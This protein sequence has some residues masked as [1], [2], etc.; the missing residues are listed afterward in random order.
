[1][2]QNIGLQY[3]SHEQTVCALVIVIAQLVSLICLA[4]PWTVA[5]QAPL[6]LEFPRQDSGVGYHFLLQGISPNQGSNPGLLHCRQILY[7]LCHLEILYF[8][9]LLKNFYLSLAA[10]CLC[11]FMRAFTVCGLRTSHCSGVSCVEHRLQGMWAQ[12]FWHVEFSW[13]RD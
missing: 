10:L 7:H 5:Q 6:S 13:T 11:C 2:C 8:L 3:Q 12:Q 1:M 9:T 4:N